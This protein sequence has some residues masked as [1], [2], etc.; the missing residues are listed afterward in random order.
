MGGKI[1]TQLITFHTLSEL[2]NGF[3]FNLNFAK[4][5]T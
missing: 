3:R 1:V 5:D 4:I 2:T